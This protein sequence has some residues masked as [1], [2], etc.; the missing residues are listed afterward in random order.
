MLIKVNRRQRVVSFDGGYNTALLES[1]LSVQDGKLVSSSSTEY[2]ARE[3]DKKEAKAER[4][5]RDNARVANLNHLLTM[6]V[7]AAGGSE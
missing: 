5:K 1:Q 7:R 6:S 3:L 4:R 2:Y